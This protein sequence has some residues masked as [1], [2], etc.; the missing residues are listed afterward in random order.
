MNKNQLIAFK[1]LLDNPYYLID[2]TNKEVF[3]YL[4]L[5]GEKIAPSSNRLPINM[6]LVIDRSGSMSGQKLTY[7]KEAV[8]FVIDNLSANDYLAIVQYDNRI[9]V[10]SEASKVVDKK[11][12]K[13]KLEAI[14][15][16]S[17][18][19]LSGGMFEGYAQVKVHKNENLVNRVLLLTDGLANNGI[20][21][22]KK[23]Q[24]IAQK[25]F[26][27]EG[28]ALSTFGVG[29]DFNEQLLT[30]LAEYGGANYYFIDNPDKI[31]EIFQEEL[32]GLLS[33]IAQ[34]T[35]FEV[36]FPNEYLSLEKVYGYTYSAG[37]NS[38]KINLNNVG[39]EEEKAVLFKFKLNKPIPTNEQLAIKA[40]LQ[41]D[42][43]VANLGRV[44][45]TETLSLQATK[46]KSVYE[47]AINR[48]A[49]EN[50]ALF[51]ANDK[52][53]EAIKLVDSGNFDE[54][55][56]CLDEAILYLNTVE[57]MGLTSDRLIELK[58][59]IVTYRQEIDEL[60]TMKRQDFIMAQKNSHYASHKM[61]K[62]RT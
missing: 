31:P 14:Q 52:Q 29:A 37:V 30:D 60:R 26:R 32:K 50:I 58:K 5:K 51:V 25:F 34:N 56:K 17:S 62:R 19:N 55:K 18:T 59:V 57:Q 2:N 40:T 43:A 15:A 16:R 7:A 24:D 23:L 46:D 3:V 44:K 4:E 42:D 22:P 49:L 6:S 21:D 10:V 27:E 38:L 61:R 54:A 39:S 11:A 13:Q 41:F 28:V 8:K 9:D 12:L 36:V 35:S 20:T 48:E 33:V 1:T 47:K 45:R 53:D